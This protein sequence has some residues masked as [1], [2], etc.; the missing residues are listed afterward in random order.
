MEYMKIIRKYNNKIMLNKEIATTYI[1]K[2]KALLKLE[3][4]VK[5]LENAI[6][7][8][9]LD[10]NYLNNNVKSLSSNGIIA[11]YVKASV[12]KTIDSEMLEKK[13]PK[14]YKECLNVKE[15]QAYIKL[16]I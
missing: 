2:K 6:K 5:V 1:E 9:L 7:K 8:E 4:E 12:R 16:C 3:E 11:S 14:A 15:V 13:H 10:G